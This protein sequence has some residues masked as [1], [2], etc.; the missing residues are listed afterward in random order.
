MRSR[1]TRCPH[2]NIL[3]CPLYLAAHIPKPGYGG[4]DD[5]R[6]DE[7]GCAV[8]RDM[9][10]VEAVARL[11]AVDPRLV[12]ELEFEEQADEMRKTRARNM[13]LAGIH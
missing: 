12:A 11:R 2:A 6:L 13:R 9:D 4:C 5:G 3:H 10:Y 7:G 8:D 1:D